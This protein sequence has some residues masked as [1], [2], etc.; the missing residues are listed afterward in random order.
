VALAEP[1]RALDARGT[2][3]RGRLRRRHALV[4][5]AD[6]IVA[7]AVDAVGVVAA[8]LELEHERTRAG[9][10]TETGGGDEAA[11]PS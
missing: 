3:H 2:L 9:E 4:V 7:G 10:S 11:G 6:E 5:F 8:L 1:I